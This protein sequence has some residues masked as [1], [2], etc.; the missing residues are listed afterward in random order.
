MAA[1][2]PETLEDLLLVSGIGER[3]LEKY[4]NEFLQVLNG[5]AAVDSDRE[6]PTVSPAG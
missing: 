1:M 2:R 5:W 4:G 3:K 6:P